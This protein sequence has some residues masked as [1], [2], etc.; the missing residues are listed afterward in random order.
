MVGSSDSS[1]FLEETTYLSAKAPTKLLI[2][3]TK[4]ESLVSVATICWAR[5][6]FNE[7]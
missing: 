5:I 7:L 6:G 2:R 1:S 4:S 3:L